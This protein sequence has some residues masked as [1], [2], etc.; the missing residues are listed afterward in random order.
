MDLN[1]Y[2]RVLSRFRYL[3]VL[4]IA[5]AGSLAVLSYYNV[6]FEGGRPNLT[7]R[8]QEVWKS[9]ALLF[10][11]EPGFPAGRR[12]LE[13]VP[14]TVGEETTLQPEYN[15][16]DRY[17]GL[18]PL[19][20]KLASSDRVRA[21]MAQGGPVEGQF[22][23]FPT[24]DTTSRRESPLPMV[25]LIGTGATPAAAETTV[26]R[27]KDA[28]LLYLRGQQSRADIPR[29]KRV[30]VQTVNEPAPAQ[31]VVPR[32]KTLPFA[33]LLAVLFATLALIFVLENMRP[34]VRVVPD[35]R[36]LTDVRRSA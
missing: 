29:D 26:R 7:P 1:L 28:F 18:A 6:R 8:A 34:A 16:P 36:P 9:E 25:S 20:A 3:L 24:V 17:T 23:A 4:G 31:L 19:Y 11:T 13:L 2:A 15:P 5:L 12:D 22:A 14:V 32:K 33:V 21:L 27:G 35:E 30:V 10:L